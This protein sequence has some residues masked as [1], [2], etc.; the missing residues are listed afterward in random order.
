MANS[1][2]WRLQD[3]GAPNHRN[4]IR[5]ASSHDKNFLAACYAGSMQ[6]IEI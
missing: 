5:L 4:L 3:T 2:A 6:L 1:K